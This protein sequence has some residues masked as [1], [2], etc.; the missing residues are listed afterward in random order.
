MQLSV[1]VLFFALILEFVEFNET[2][3]IIR[4]YKFYNRHS[5]HPPSVW[6]P[7][8]KPQRHYHSK[9]MRPPKYH[10]HEPDYHKYVPHSEDSVDTFNNDKPYVIIIQF[11]QKKEKKE[12]QSHQRQHIIDFP[13]DTDYIEDD[14]DDDDELKL[15]EIDDKG[16]QVKINH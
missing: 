14:D 3:K 6:R 9:K 4:P 8:P 15:Y 5:W 7:F 11:P 12:H 16:V 10:S 1:I 2:Y 13:R